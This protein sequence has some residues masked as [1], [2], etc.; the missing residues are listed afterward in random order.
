MKPN[1][2][3]AAASITSQTSTPSLSQTIGHLVDQ[4]DV[5][6][7]EGVLQQLHQLGGLGRR[8][9]H[10]RIDRRLVQRARHLGR[11]A[12]VMPPTTFGVFW[13]W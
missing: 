2:L 13:V 11:Q 3:V 9:R 7:A 12:G 8:D 10:Q 4:A 1:G 5:H 6:A